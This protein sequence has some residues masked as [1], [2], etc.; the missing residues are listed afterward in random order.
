MPWKMPYVLS[1]ICLH[2]LENERN[3]E[4]Q[5]FFFQNEGL[6][7]I[8]R[9]DTVGLNDVVVSRKRCKIESLLV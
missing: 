5:L 1:K 3:M 6:I 8:T 7:K 9:S 2:V 4:L